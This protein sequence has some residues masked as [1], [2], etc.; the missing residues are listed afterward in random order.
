MNRKRFRPRRVAKWVGLSLCAGIVLLDLLSLTGSVL[1]VSRNHR[2]MIGVR[3][4]DFLAALP[5]AKNP[6]PSPREGHFRLQDN[7]LFDAPPYR[8]P[9]KKL[10]P[11]WEPN[12]RIRALWFQLWLPLWIPLAC[13]ALPTALLVWAD[14][15]RIRP[16][17]CRECGY[18]LTGN[19]SGRCPECGAS[20][21]AGQT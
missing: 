6:F 7:Q 15:R 2:W 21:S 11:Y 9:K 4:H 8:E 13:V 14:R 3:D 19:V 17:H 5:P 1:W 10:W 12:R 20:T 16:G 18:D